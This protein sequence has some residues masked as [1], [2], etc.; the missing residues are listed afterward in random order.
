MCLVQIFT[1]NIYRRIEVIMKRE[2]PDT[3]GVVEI[4]E[5]SLGYMPEEK[6]KGEGSNITLAKRLP[7]KFQNKFVRFVIII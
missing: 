5:T 3:F 2:I 1:F 7:D 6:R 4:V